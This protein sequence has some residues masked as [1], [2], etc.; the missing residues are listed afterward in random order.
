MFLDLRDELQ[1]LGHVDEHVGTSLILRKRDEDE[2]SASVRARFSFFLLLLTHR[3]KAPDLPSIGNV[4]SML[5]GE[6]PC[7]DWRKEEE[8]VR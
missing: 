8:K 1:S 3:P 5:V 7:S 6:D 4:P 2:T